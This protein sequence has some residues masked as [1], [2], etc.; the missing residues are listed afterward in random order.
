MNRFACA[1]SWALAV[2]APAAVL[3]QS[4]PSHP[5]TVLVPFAP[6]GRA[7]AIARIMAERIVENISGA[8]DSIGVGRVA[9]GARRPTISIGSSSAHGFS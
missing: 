5:I 8:S 6:G 7:D 3:G 9:R 4:Y 2:A 1:L